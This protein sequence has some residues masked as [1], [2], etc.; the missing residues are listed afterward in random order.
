MIH[1][2]EQ[3]RNTI[4]GSFDSTL[5]DSNLQ[6]LSI[7]IAEFAIDSVL[8]DGLF[9]EIPIINTVINLSKIGANIRDRLFLKKIISF[10][11]QLKDIPSEKRKKMIDD[12]NNSQKYRVKVGEKLLYIIDSCEDYEISELIGSVFKYYLEENITYDEFLKTS[13]VLKNMNKSNFNWF[14]KERKN[15]FFD[16][17][18][19][20][21]L[22]HTGLFELYYDNVNVDIEKET[23]HKVLLEGG[24]EYK[25]STDGGVGVLL[26]R[27][28]EIILEIFCSTYKKPKTIKI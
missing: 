1:Q 12:I 21:D 22:M 25:A 4:Q 3:Q 5:T 20:G 10:M 9:K 26:S 11:S 24:N 14:I 8:N 18:D 2:S 28:G 17:S 23:D 6:N 7:D 16:L 27:A 15:H 19:V 13:S